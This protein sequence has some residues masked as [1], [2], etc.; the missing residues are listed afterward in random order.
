[1]ASFEELGANKRKWITAV[2]TPY[3][4]DYLEQAKVVHEPTV[5]KFIELVD[6]ADNSIELF[7]IINKE[8][9]KQRNQLLRVFKKYVL[10][11][12]S[13]EDTKIK[14][15][16]ED[17]I[18]HNLDEFR[19]IKQV[20]KL[21]KS[22]PEDDEALIAVLQEYSTRGQ[23][24]YSLTE[25]FFEWF[26]NNFGEDYQI[27]GPKRAGA[28]IQLRT[29]LKDFS[30]EAPTDFIIKNNKGRVIAVGYAR[31]DSDRGGA[32]EDDRT[33]GNNDKITKIN[34]YNE[35]TGSKIKIIFLNDGPGLVLGSMWRDYSQIDAKK[36]VLVCTLKML[37]YRLTA[38]WLSDDSDFVS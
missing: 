13:T 29:V 14:S 19:D 31:Y 35:R 32:Q 11:G 36:G 38:D 6:V 22:R 33:S 8:K 2:G 21:V 25:A 12:V 37:D 3:Y 10:P 23:K 17:I 15:H 34:E 5:R 1:M 16:V 24:G 30:E 20:R 7:R 9:G 28:D 27:S 18:E 4:P 26:E